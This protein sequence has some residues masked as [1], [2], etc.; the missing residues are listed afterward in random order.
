MAGRAGGH[1]IETD[2]SA[3]TTVAM[4]SEM[5]VGTIEAPIGTIGVKIVGRSP[6]T[7]TRAA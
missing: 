2:G 3:E 4:S 5:V 7:N 1:G 6:S